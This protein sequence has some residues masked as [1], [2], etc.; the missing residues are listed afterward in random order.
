MEAARSFAG[1]GGNLYRTHVRADPDT[2]LDWDKPLSGQSPTIKNALE[3]L[4]NYKRWDKGGLLQRATG[5]TVYNNIK[6]NKGG[7]RAASAMLARAGVPGIR[8]LDQGSRQAGG[9]HNYVVF[10]PSIIDIAHKNGQPVTPQQAHDMA[11]DSILP[12][13]G[14]RRGSGSTPITAPLTMFSALN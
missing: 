10:D 8:Y 9:T 4:G 12:S 3:A 11:M 1:D 6:D 2:F 14:T 7:D 13:R 5:Q